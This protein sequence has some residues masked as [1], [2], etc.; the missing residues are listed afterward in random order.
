MINLAHLQ[1]IAQELPKAPSFPVYGTVQTTLIAM[2]I[3]LVGAI[4]V[5]YVLKHWPLRKNKKLS[6]ATEMKFTKLMIVIVWAALLAA[7][8]DVWWHRAVGRDSFWELPHMFMYSFATLGI[9]WGL[10]IWRRTNE[11]IWR[12]ISIA[13]FLV[14][15]TAPFDNLWHII[16]GVENLS[17][18]ISLSWS[19]PHAALD[20]AVMA[21]LIFILRVL[22]RHHETK[23]QTIFASLIF[24]LLYAQILFLLMPFHPTEGWGQVFGFWGAGILALAFVG[25]LLFAESWINT[26]MAAT[27]TAVF[28]VLL[29]LT[30]FGKETAPGI[31]ILPHDRP[32][33]WLYVFSYVATGLFLDL[34][35]KLLPLPM[36]GFAAGFLWSTILFGFAWRFFAPEFQ[37]NLA[38]ILTAILSASVGGLLAAVILE[39]KIFIKND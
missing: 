21:V 1:A 11:T 18:P 16:F 35:K 3:M 14:P 2:A 12:K 19:P 8:W 9:L 10:Y 33:I 27:L 26:E 5:Y 13:L 22:K 37:Y 4:V 28:A 6:V 38:D 34:S 7:S 31:I 25:I 32:P 24:G 39:N 29:M 20:F 17:K 23:D 30:S 15:L 36:R